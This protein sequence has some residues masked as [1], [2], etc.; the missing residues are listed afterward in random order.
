MYRSPY[1][2]EPDQLIAIGASIVLAWLSR[3]LYLWIHRRRHPGVPPF[4]GAGSSAAILI[5][6]GFLNLA[7]GSAS[8]AGDGPGTVTVT[9]TAIGAGMLVLAP[10]VAL[11]GKR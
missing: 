5:G 6:I 11:T 3:E 1:D 10:L 8:I 4:E 2:L 7:F 9:L